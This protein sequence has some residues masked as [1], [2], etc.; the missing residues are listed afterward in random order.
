MSN[1]VRCLLFLSS[2][3]R[4]VNSGRNS[5][6][7]IPTSPEFVRYYGKKHDKQIRDKQIHIRLGIVLNR[8]TYT[9][10]VW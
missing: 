3:V 1:S 4:Y 5:D 9:L 2:G 8:N 6:G 10:P 7:G